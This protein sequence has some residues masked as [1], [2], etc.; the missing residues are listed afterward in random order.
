MENSLGE[1]SKQ[2]FK[3]LHLLYS[4]DDKFLCGNNLGFLKRPAKETLYW[5]CI[6]NTLLYLYTLQ[7]LI[8]S[9]IGFLSQKHNELLQWIFNKLFSMIW[10]KLR[11]KSSNLTYDYEDLNQHIGSDT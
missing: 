10:E 4:T 5:F 7:A 9:A 6:I 1:A 3:I 11:I 8:T 2:P